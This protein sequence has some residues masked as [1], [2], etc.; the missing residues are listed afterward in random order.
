MFRIDRTVSGR[1]FVDG[2]GNPC[3]LVSEHISVAAGFRV[4]GVGATYRRPIAVERGADI[5]PITDVVMITRLVGLVAV[6]LAMI[7][8]VIRR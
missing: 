7:V 5:V 8:G 3:A 4:A 1:E 6:T 2:A